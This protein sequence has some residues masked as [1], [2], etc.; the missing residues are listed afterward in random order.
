[1]VAS[2]GGLGNKTGDSKDEKEGACVYTNTIT[3]VLLQ[4][5]IMTQDYDIFREETSPSAFVFIWETLETNRGTWVE[6]ILHE[7]A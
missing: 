3:A 7:E 1:M 6:F 2:F 4:R 5:R